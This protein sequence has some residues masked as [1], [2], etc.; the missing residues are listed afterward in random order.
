[1]KPKIYKKDILTHL[2]LSFLVLLGFIEIANAQKTSITG[3]VIDDKGGPVVAASILIKGSA[4]GTVSDTEGRYAL[5]ANLGDVLVISSV[6]FL[7]L[8]ITVSGTVHNITMVEDANLLQQVVVIGYGSLEKR[9]V[10]SAITNVDEKDFNR[11]N[12]NS[13][14][15]LLQGKV[16]GLSIV[17]PQGNPNGNFDIRLRGLSTLGANSQPLIII[18]GV[19][20]VNLNS[21]DPNDIATIDVLKDGGAAA[22]YGTRGSSGVIIITTK[23]GS[24]GRPQLEYSGY[25]TSES[26]DRSHPV[27]DKSTYLAN[28]GTDLG[29]DNT[30]LDNITRNAISHVHNVSLSGGANQFTYRASLNFRDAQGVLRNS[31]FRQLNGRLNLRQKAFNNKLTVGLNIASTSRTSK[32]GFDDAFK[33]AI[34]MPPTAPTVSDDPF[35][36]KY[37]GYFQSEVYDLYNPVAIIDQNHNDQRISRLMYNVYADYKI[38]N[39]LSAAIQY[40]QNNDNTDNNQYIS[41]YSYYGNGVNRNGLA[42][43]QTLNNRNDLLEMTG[44]YSKTFG[45]VDLSLLAGYS[46]QNYTNNNFFTQAGNFLTDAFLYN[47]FAAA[48]DFADGK[49]VATSSKDNN[50]LIA[51]F[52]RANF[53]YA[54]TYFLTASLRREGSSRFGTGNKWGNFP[55]VSAGIDISKLVS[56]PMV[57]QLKVRASYGVTGNLPDRSYLSQQL[58]GPGSSVTYFYY[59]GVY[60]PVYSPQSNPNPNLKW[61][62]KSEI[63]FGLDFSM[64]DNRLTGSFDYYNR[65]TSDALITLEVPVPP[66]LFSTSLLNA[67]E[68][69]NSGIELGLEYL[70]LKNE[71]FSWSAR[72]TFA[73]YQ[74]DVVSL[75]V[76]DIQYGIREVG[77][78]PAPLTGNVVRVQE[79]QPIG[80]IIGWQYEGV[81]EDGKYI[82]KDLDNNGTINELDMTIIGNG[83][84]KGE[85]GLFNRFTLGNFDL[86]VFFR[87]VYGHDLINLNRSMYEQASRI[88]S[89]NLIN[90]DGYDPKYT[91]PAAFNSKYVENA[92]F[93]KLDNFTIGYNFKFKPGAKVNGMRAYV[94]GQNLFYITKYQGVDP[95]PRYTYQNNVLAPGVE[96]LNSWVT[97]RSFSVGLNLSF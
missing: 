40:S 54:N 83:L 49:A 8:E 64:F 26:T 63:D 73:T 44:N 93:I 75:S 29:G 3:T 41:K 59:N 95:E 85:A 30:W 62:T 80:Q 6:S 50:K 22:I 18:D 33:Y 39:D 82:L 60:V 51:F 4:T 71:K 24:S 78:L 42:S 79:G 70:I 23:N 92:S 53:S 61:E 19:A 81:A 58:Y 84:P 9:K 45:E 66:N 56:I 55:G 34:I 27:M 37:G 17:A 76:G 89:Y 14:A 2:I 72:A 1:M 15:Q 52:G 69:K 12:I 11:G 28:G 57:D 96:P 38:T 32:L 48:K 74:S 97:T 7:T 25:V 20:G 86:S 77:S 21:V 13:P 94:S 68:L 43:K 16:A 35:F 90:T 36:D 87:G 65:K 46:H 47:N 10:T 67:G 88:S 31:G 5:V 91:G